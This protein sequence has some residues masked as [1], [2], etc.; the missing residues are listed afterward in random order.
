M[1]VTLMSISPPTGPGSNGAPSMGGE[2][3]QELSPPVPIPRPLP[4]VE[5][6]TDRNGMLRDA[7]QEDQTRRWPILPMTLP[8]A[9]VGGPKSALGD[10]RDRKKRSPQAPVLQTN[11]SLT[12]TRR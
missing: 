9:Q 10:A 1:R 4:T 12:V 2:C 11:T 5:T 3:H 7:R 8:Q 6:D